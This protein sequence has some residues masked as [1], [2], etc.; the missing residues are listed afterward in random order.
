MADSRIRWNEKEKTLLSVRVGELMTGGVTQPLEALRQAQSVLPRER[1]R[2]IRTLGQAPW[3]KTRVR[4]GTGFL[5]AA[6]IPGTDSVGPVALHG[7]REALVQ[8]FV[9]FFREVLD[10]VAGEPA[11][12]RPK[13][14]RAAKGHGRR[15][16]RRA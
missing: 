1:R 10:R 8:A 16:R 7:G 15:T 11:A 9:D 13:R 2:V 3:L 4:P 5:A 6:R 12:A 14:A